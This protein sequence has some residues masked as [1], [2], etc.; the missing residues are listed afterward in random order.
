V[1]VQATAGEGISDVSCQHFDG[2]RLQASVGECMLVDVMSLCWG[3]TYTFNIKIL[4]NKD[5]ET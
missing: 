5:W 3:Q 4:Q 1:Q 2:G